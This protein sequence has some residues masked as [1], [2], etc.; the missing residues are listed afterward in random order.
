MGK[1]ERGYSQ[2]EWDRVVGWGTVPEEYKIKDG[3]EKLSVVCETVFPEVCLP[4]VAPYTR[5]ELDRLGCSEGWLKA[6]PI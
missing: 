3:E 2:S 6:E 5:A 4:E 1:I